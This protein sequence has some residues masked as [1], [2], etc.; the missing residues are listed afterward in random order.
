M[1]APRVKAEDFVG[2]EA[3]LRQREEE[4]AAVLCTLTVDDH[5]SKYG[6]KRYMLGREPVLTRDGAAITD[7]RGRRAYV[8]SAGARPSI[9][10]NILMWYL[11][12]GN[13]VT[14]ER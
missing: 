4:P 2:K 14:G 5:T 11:P 7:R 10:K 9:G 6:E 13:A 8:K 12:P 1:Q 3:H